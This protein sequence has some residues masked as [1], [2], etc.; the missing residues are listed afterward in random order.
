MVRL[1]GVIIF[2]SFPGGELGNLC[3]NRIRASYI[4][5]S[6][7]AL[8]AGR[9]RINDLPAISDA[10]MVVLVSRSRRFLIYAEDP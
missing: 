6:Q 3:I 9:L 8:H 1:V 2:M 7:L 10:S 5:L 4:K